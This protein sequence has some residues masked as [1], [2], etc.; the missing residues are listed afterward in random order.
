METLDIS[1]H[2]QWPRRLFV[3][4]TG[5]DVG[6][7]F[8]TGWLARELNANGV[9]CTTLK[10]I[11]TGNRGRSEDIERHREIMGV[12]LT[13]ED[14]TLLTAPQI[15]SYPCSPDLASR[16]DG[17]A[18]DFGTI[19]ASIAILSAKHKVVLIEGAGGLM[20]PL[21]GQLLTADWIAERNMPTLLVVS[22]QLGSINH[23]LLTLNAMMSYGIDLYAVIYNPYF[24]S[25]KVICTDTR[26]Y[27]KEWIVSR[28]PRARWIEM[29]LTVCG[30]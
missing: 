9:D 15:F 21:E 25:D 7:T 16:I 11:Q 17:R 22:G 1:A 19:E 30:Q 8:A 2:T 28:Y 3:T 12:P 20:V 26:R 27:L 13:D 24:D 4:G 14:T 18:I 23:A 5:T 6:K 29:P 10:M